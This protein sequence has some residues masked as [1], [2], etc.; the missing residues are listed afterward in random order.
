[1]NRLYEQLLSDDPAWPALAAQAASAPN[2]AVILPP[3]EQTS[4]RRTIEALQVTTRSTLGA[5][6]HETGGLLVDHGWLRMLG[7]GHP[8]LPRALGAWN[9]QLRVP[10]EHFLIVAD[11]V[12]GGV[13]AINGG[14]L[15]EALGRVFY[16]AP[17]TCTWENTG[18]GHSAFVS[19]AFEGN[20]TK[21]YQGLRWP[22]WEAE[23]DA[24]TGDAVLHLWPPPWTVEGQDVS[25]VSRRA[26]PATEHWSLAGGSGLAR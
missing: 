3:P 17:D 16:F 19:W 20:L 8:R 18:L 4:R 7:A 5:L 2:G 9:G 22:G 6:A 15:G 12:L 14:A 26:I 21:F 24:L 11:D 10:V 23:A 1:M 13:F 25:C